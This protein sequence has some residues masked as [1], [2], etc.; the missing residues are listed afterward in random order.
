MVCMCVFVRA[1][2]CACVKVHASV[3]ALTMLFVHYM[4][5]CMYVYTVNELLN[6]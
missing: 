2:A 3:C 4:C 6:W 5:T 1:R